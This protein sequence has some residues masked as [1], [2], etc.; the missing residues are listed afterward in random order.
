M[1]QYKISTRAFSKDGYII[2]QQLLKELPYGM[3]HS[4]YNGCGWIAAYNF[5]H[6]CGRKKEYDTVRQ[7]LE[8]SLILG[9]LLGTHILQLYLY[10]RRHGFH[11]H[12]A[13]G[14]KAAQPYAES[15]KAGILFYFNGR[16]LHF[17]TF[18][19]APEYE[20]ETVEHA[21][22]ASEESGESET[23]EKVWYRFFNARIGRQFDYD[24]MD[25]FLAKESQTAV[26]VQITTESV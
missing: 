17:V 3:K 18:V 26:L 15:C 2:N 12:C 24:T 10:L 1:E 14:Q 5:L 19:P 25:N 13:L 4:D 6:A 9:G 22:A 7:Q 21:E 20:E 23:S 11:L 16:A 8:D